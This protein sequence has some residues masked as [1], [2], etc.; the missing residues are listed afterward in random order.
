MQSSECTVV[1]ASCD[2]YAD[3]LEPFSVL[4]KKFW[5][6]CPFETVLVTETAPSATLCFDRVVAC[7]KG[8][9]W[10]SRLVTALERISTPRVIMLCDDYLLNGSVDTALVLKRLEQAM[11]FK[12]VN[13]RLI[14]CPK[15][16][17]TASEGLLEY[18]K[19][20]A[21]C[22]ATQAGIWDR[23]F[24]KTL[25][26]G[27]SSIWEFE[28]YGSFGLENEV[29]PILC[30][31]TKE[32]P[33]V[34][35]VHKGCWEKFG[36]KVLRDNG[37]AADLSKRGLPSFKTRFIE[38]F[39]ALVFALVPN[40]WIVRLQN[41]LAVGAKEQ[42]GN[43]RSCGGRIDLVSYEHASESDDFPHD[44]RN[45]RGGVHPF[46]AAREQVGIDL[47]RIRMLAEEVSA[48]L[49]RT[50][51]HGAGVSVSE[52]SAALVA[53]AKKC[54]L[55]IPPSDRVGFG[56]LKRRRSG[57][58][59]VYA[60][61]DYGVLVKFKD[62]LAKQAL[63]R[64]ASGDWLYEHVIHN[65]LFPEA[66]YE[67]LG[68][69]ESAG[70]VRI[71]LRQPSV[72]ALFRPT[73][74]RIAADMRAL[75]LRPEERYFFGNDVLAVTDVSAASDNVLQGNDGKTYYIDP[76]IRL[77][78]PAREVIEWLVGEVTM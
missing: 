34:D 32:F 12:A 50:V 56:D 39:K 63:K 76:L 65:I 40:T 47:G 3:L 42:P 18:R 6:D 14:P 25:A 36:L 27:K 57:E 54:G 38:G 45:Y 19:N 78:R 13:L 10:C 64:T 28:R 22:I 2:K 49:V 21:Y 66:R 17:Q 67:F 71:V 23:E 55:F 20:T 74:G 77:K 69:S 29:R 53:S 52:M 1:V 70:A 43:G 31:P 60:G 58:S 7:G 75:G 48:E 5:P 73:D 51:Q 37:L 61:P 41:A 46:S 4:W 26:T 8:G 59:E 11:R 44:Q 15:P 72:N 68:V 33:F 24:L 16:T 30:T 62:P 9:N 35:A